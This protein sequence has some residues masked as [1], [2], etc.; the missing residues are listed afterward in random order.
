M[1]LNEEKRVRLADALARCQGAVSGTGASTPSAPI[2]AILLATAQ[3]SP[4]P[5]P[6]EKS[7]GMIAIDSDEDEDTEEGIVFKRRRVAAAT[8]SHSSTEAPPSSHRDQHPLTLP[9]SMN[10]LLLKTVGRVPPRVSTCPLL[11]SYPPPSNTP[12]R[13]SKRG[14]QRRSW[15]KT[16]WR[17]AWGQSL[18]DFLANSFAF[19]RQARLRAQEEL[20]DK[21]GEETEAKAK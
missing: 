21:V 12:L 20:E 16:H 6:L 18:G 4:M 8:T 1:V 13:G 2:A 3:A 7:K 5:T 19:A 14:R 10:H 17:S 11:L 9:L 15:V